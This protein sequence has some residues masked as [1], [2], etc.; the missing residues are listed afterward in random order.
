MPDIS[1]RAKGYIG[2]PT[3]TLSTLLEKAATSKDI[4]SFG[5]GAPSLA[6]PKEAIDYITEKM[7]ENPKKY[8]S[9][10]S[11]EGLPQERE[12]I[13]EYLKQHEN[14][15]ID[16]DQIMIGLGSSENLFCA[17][18]ALLNPGDEII[19]ADPSYV[20]YPGPITS[21]GARIR[22]VNTTWEDDFQLDLE[23]VKEAVNEKTKAMLI[24]TPDNPTG[25][26]LTDEN[27]KGLLDICEDKDLWA[28]TDDV[29]KDI[30]FEGKFTNARH[31]GNE[32]KIISFVSMSKSC[33]IPGI[34]TGY[35]Y[36]PKEVIF[37]INEIKQGTTLSPS[38]ISQLAIEAF[39]KNKGEIKDKFVKEQV[40][41][42]YKEKRDIL[43][44]ALKEHLPEANFSI[45]KGAF[46]VFPNMK[47]YMDKNGADCKAFTNK[48]LEKSGVAAIPG[49]FFGPQ[50]DNNIRLTFVTETEERINEGIKRISD[51]L[52]G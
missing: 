16:A 52:N 24:L 5:G 25:R 17:F 21:T 44:K 18:E 7:K 26:T 28:L 13:S 6:P 50:C 42:I 23:K 3:R 37:K 29:Y 8:V 35:A 32:E 12:L 10:T 15:N 48:L 41:P 39:Y 51:L 43:I 22:R 27:I 9:Y 19:L 30:I 47:Y 34:R 31:L 2:S 20:G 4:I 33:S 1:D 40:I 11:T 14:V 49:V 45:P 46:Y 36:G 38:R